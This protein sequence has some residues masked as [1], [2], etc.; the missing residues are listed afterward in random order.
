VVVDSAERE[1]GTWA[2]A[3][4]DLRHEWTPLYVRDP[5]DKPGNRALIA[6]GARSFTYQFATRESLKEYLAP[7]E[8]VVSTAA[9]ELAPSAIPAGT[10]EPLPK[11]IVGDAK[12]L[13]DNAHVVD[14]GAPLAITNESVSTESLDLFPLF[15]ERLPSVLG[16][17][18]KTEEE[19]RVA[20]GLEKSQVK[21]WLAAAVSTG[22]VEKLKKPVAYALPKQKSLC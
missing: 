18:S 4:E 5:G 11:E 10:T 2:G 6:K 3:I 19:I 12:P 14:Q 22:C 7:N 17:G 20:L 1:G 8:S 15:L 13:D 16:A 21:A 9:L